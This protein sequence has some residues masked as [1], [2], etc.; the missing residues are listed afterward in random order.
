MWVLLGVFVLLG[1]QPSEAGTGDHTQARPAHRAPAILRY[2]AVG[3]SYTAGAGIPPVEVGGCF[4]S[5]RNYP[6]R[7]AERLG[8]RLVDASCGGA[9]IEHA[10]EPQTA[11]EVINRPQLDGI[12][13]RTDLV[14]ISLGVNDANFAGLLGACSQVG[15]QDPGGSPCRALF[16]G[17][18]GDTLLSD[19]AKVGRRLERVI[20]QVREKAP[21]AAVVVIGY[22]LLAP[23]HGTC[24]GLPFAAGDYA[25]L[26]EFLMDVD[27][28]LWAA[29]RHTDARYVDLAGPSKGHD[30][31]AGADAW[32][33]GA[34]SSPRAM[35][36][37][38]FANEQR[39]VA[40]LVVDALGGSALP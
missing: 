28:A 6:H 5:G 20:G 30:I 14:T 13:R 17:P 39:A 21:D 10:E 23:A 11:G 37:H 3:D 29:A 34:I 1:G 38:P 32:V 7:I 40:D 2:V 35:V 9:K 33:L 24:P 8:A 31:C 18:S 27:A 36:W 25:F 26:N 16:R 15:A 19:I 12:D 4:R 22:P